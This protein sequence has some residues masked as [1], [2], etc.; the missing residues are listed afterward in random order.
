MGH[1]TD[2][3][4]AGGTAAEPGLVARVLADTATH[5]SQHRPDGPLG[6]HS[7]RAVISA[8][9]SRIC[10]RTPDA[11]ATRVALAAVSAA[12]APAKN[13]TRGQYARR[14]SGAIG[15]PAAPEREGA[16]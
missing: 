15:T 7:L 3:K 5:L 4:S 6:R 12:P 10:G 16:R 9:A 2:L 8:T 14:L 1:S 11:R 13:T